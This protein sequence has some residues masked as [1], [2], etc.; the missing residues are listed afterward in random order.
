MKA[1]VTEPHRR[2]KDRHER[3]DAPLTH[4]RRKEVEKGAMVN[5]VEALATKAALSP[6]EAAEKIVTVHNQLMELYLR[7]RDSIRPVA[8]RELAHS[9]DN[10]GLCVRSNLDWG[11]TTLRFRAFGDKA[12]FTSQLHRVDTRTEQAGPAQGTGLW[13]WELPGVDA[14]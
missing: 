9:I 8:S 14:R 6:D 2:A 11:L 12:S 10:I 13:W 1:P 4:Q 7:R 3:F 5:T